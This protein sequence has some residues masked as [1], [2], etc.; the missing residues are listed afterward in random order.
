ME[1]KT[2]RHDWSSVGAQK[3]PGPSGLQR[4]R[5]Y[6]CNIKSKIYTF[7]RMRRWLLSLLSELSGTAAPSPFVPSPA[8]MN[9]PLAEGVRLL[10][11]G[12]LPFFPPSFLFLITLHG[13]KGKEKA[14]VTNSVG[15]NVAV[16]PSGFSRVPLKLLHL[17]TGCGA[18]SCT[19]CLSLSSW[20]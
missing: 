5:Q 9:D 4:T 13:K 19:S 6:K 15:I 8:D 20:L 17:S 1:A 14:N 2:I 11:V 3:G 7:A 16:Q 10:H 12:S 18:A